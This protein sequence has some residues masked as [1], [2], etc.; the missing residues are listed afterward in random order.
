MIPIFINS[1]LYFYEIRGSAIKLFDG[2]EII[3][4]K[5]F[6]GVEHLPKQLADYEKQKEWDDFGYLKIVGKILWEDGY[7][8]EDEEK[9]E[10]LKQM[11]ELS[12]ELIEK[13]NKRKKN[14]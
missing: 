14:T 2:D 10:N 8:M 11:H 12:G 6:K 7:D 5:R 4:T 1:K 9:L 13:I 3:F